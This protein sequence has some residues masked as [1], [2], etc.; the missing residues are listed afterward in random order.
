MIRVS[1]HKISQIANKGKLVWLDQLFIDYRHDLEIYINYIIDGVLPLKTQ[2]SSKLLPIERIK[3]SHYRRE[4]YAHASSIIRSQ[5]K[6]A[7]KRR[8]EVY[9]KC[10]KY[11]KKNG[12]QTAFVKTRFKHLQKTKILHSKYFTIPEIK[13]LTI[14]LGAEFVNS[15]EGK[16]FDNFFSIRLP[17]FHK[18]SKRKPEGIKIN[19]PFKHHRHS[20]QFKDKG[21]KQKDTISIKKVGQD[22]YISL[23][24]EKHVPKIQTKSNKPT[25]TIGIDTGYRRLIATSE[26]QI[27]GDNMPQIYQHIV[28]V[29][30]NSKHYKRLLKQR[31]NLVNFYCNQIDLTDVTKVVVED[32]FE[33]KKDSK[34]S[35]RVNDLLSRW[36][37]RAVLIKIARMC[38]VNG[39]ELVKVSPQYTS[40]TCSSCGEAHKESRQGDFYKCVSCGHE[41]DADIN[42]AINIRNKGASS[43]LDQKSD[44]DIETFCLST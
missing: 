33:V 35:P 36:T 11:F 7:T 9:K 39:I 13:N 25:K 41:I 31:D 5:I 12:R 6:Q 18:L 17:Y 44:F 30:R 42:A 20:N 10:Y 4:I 1:K 19:I 8:Y 29:E 27:L 26:G 32:L 38:E 21:Y 16:F 3:H 15:Q 34:Y 43:P 22:Y 40:Q 14:S 24:W 28:K 2:L 37:Y 23:N